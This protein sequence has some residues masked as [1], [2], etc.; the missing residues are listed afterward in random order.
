MM[1]KKGNTQ[2]TPYNKQV[3]NGTAGGIVTE[4]I[5]EEKDTLNDI[6]KRYGIS[7]EA[8]IAANQDMLRQP[9]DLV[10]PGLHIK[11]PRKI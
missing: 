1:E 7:I 11:I 2:Q 5:A 9:S 6:A 3:A 8:I 4:Y 10:Q